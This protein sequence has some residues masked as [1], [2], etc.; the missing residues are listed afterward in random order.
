M[1][2]KD[3][4]AFWAILARLLT[5]GEYTVVLA[6]ESCT[7][8]ARESISVYTYRAGLRGAAK[9]VQN[10]VFRSKNTESAGRWQGESA[11]GAM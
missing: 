3:L 11:N 4:G 7:G 10:A 8:E 6:L 9:H 1:H 2:A 5:D